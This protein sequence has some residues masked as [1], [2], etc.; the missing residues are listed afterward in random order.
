MDHA[1]ATGD[2]ID[3]TGKKRGSKQEGE[4][5]ESKIVH[6]ETRTVGADG[7]S[8]TVCQSF[9]GNAKAAERT[10]LALPENHDGCV[11]I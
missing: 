4:E 2:G 10:T 3:E 11:P 9:A 8:A 6:G 5:V 1:A 7:N